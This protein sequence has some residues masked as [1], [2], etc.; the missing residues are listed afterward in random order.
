MISPTTAPARVVLP[1]AAIILSALIAIVVSSSPGV[2]AHP[3]E[4]G[5]A[6]AD[7]HQDAHGVAC[8][9]SGNHDQTASGH[10]WIDPVAGRRGD[11]F[12]LHGSGFPK[13]TVTIFEG[14]DD[15]VDEGEILS[16]VSVSAHRGAFAE[17]G[18]RARGMAGSSGY[19][20]WVIDSEGKTSSVFFD[21]DEH[22]V[23]FEPATA[24]A[25][26]MLRIDFLDW[27]EAPDLRDKRVGAVYI[28]GREAYI[29]GIS[30]Y[31]ECYEYAGLAEPDEMGAISVEVRVPPDVLTGEQT[32]SIYDEDALDSGSAKQRCA[33]GQARG[34]LVDNELKAR[35]EGNAEPIVRETVHVISQ[36]QAGAPEVE[37]GQN[38]IEV[39]GGRDRLITLHIS[40]PRVGGGGYTG[41][42]DQIEITLPGF[43][44]AGASFDSDAE[45][46]LVKFSGSEDESPNSA[47]DPSPDR[48]DIDE[49][50]G[51]LI[52][53][54]PRGISVAHGAGEY[55][56]VTINEG[57]GILTPEVPRGFDNSDE[58]YLVGIILIDR[59]AGQSN[60]KYETSDENIV[61]VKNPISSSVPSEIVR[62][63]LIA[64]AETEI[65][66]GEEITVDFSGPSPD[67]DFVVPTSI[68]VAR[69]TIDPLTQASF[70][71]TGLLIRGARV[72]MTIPSG[73]RAKTIPEGEFSITFSPSARIKNPFAA[74]NKVITVSS[75]AKGDEPDEITAV[76]ERTTVIDTLEGPRG[77][78]FTLEGKGYSQGTVTIY[79]DA[80]NSRRIDAGETLASVN[81][82]RG[83]FSVDLIARG[84]PGDLLY[85]VR[86]KDS[87]GVDD[88]VVF[89]I[90]SGMLFKPAAAGVGFPLQITISDWQDPRQEVAAVRLAGEEAYVARAQEYENC[91]E[92]EGV[93]QANAEG[94]VALEIDVPR[95]VPGGQQTVAVYGPEQLEHIDVDGN[96]LPDKGPCSDLPEGEPRGAAVASNVK[97]RLK[98]EPIAIIKNTIEI[99]TQDL[100]L[101]PATAARGQKVTITGS[102]FRRS[103]GGSGHVDSVWIGGNKVVDD[104]SG[105]EVGTDGNLAFA[106][107][108]PLNVAHGRN[109]VRIEGTGHTIGQATLHVPQAAITLDPALSQ[110]GTE[111]KVTGSGFI[112]NEPVVVTYSSGPAVTAKTPR[113]A[114]SASMADSQGRFEL[115]LMVPDA[116]EVGRAHLVSAVAE[117][118]T[119]DGTVSVDAE[120]QHMV[121]QA[122]IETAPVPVSPGDRMTIRGQNLPAFTPVGRVSIAGRGVLSSNEVATNGEGSFEAKVLVPNVDYGDHTLLVQVAG[123]V[124]TR[125]IKVAPPPLSGPPDQVFKDLIRTGTLRAV[126]QYDNAIQ[127]WN[128]FD[129]E[130]SEASAELNDLTEIGS[131]DIVWINLEKPEHFQDKAL[132]AGWNLIS[133]K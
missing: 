40:P 52:L 126:W 68:S 115:T 13:G 97:T 2:G 88:G 124:I 110:W 118:K 7:T 121:A 23:S 100:E 128:L 108:V 112:A 93:F 73:T 98:S 78:E 38:I 10:I 32:V 132:V 66:A 57:T 113:L 17:K 90:R 127:E 76:I 122:D 111:F 58:G 19:E 63:E 8:S 54:L 71:P 82:V 96:V 59:D 79:H 1:L 20:V 3:C 25:G 94:A 31:E 48:V 80:N 16:A 5:L 53:T 83:A 74:G 12:T 75:T 4:D 105:F 91:F 92:Y 36:A 30:E 69:I 27:N 120:A 84:R 62:V 21:I 35:L 29:S 103:G 39:D 43:D 86:T 77:T 61:V 65:G 26:E 37:R 117:V 125:I 133:L 6:P 49:L 116:A 14:T 60:P 15:V 129:P 106:V 114:Q 56:I 102:G 47:D 81:T 101:T 44:L 22:T 64:Y 131:G 70:R 41:E 33:P 24:I 9:E 28:A 11:A 51:K 50:A 99:D 34:G 123:V 109:E 85:P 95:F 87:E 130:F 67:S 104:H 18:L 46:G 119:R 72:T 89:V 107:T 45:R 42:G 55:L